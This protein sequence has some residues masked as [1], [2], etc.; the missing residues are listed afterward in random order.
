MKMTIVMLVAFLPLV[1]FAQ[2][3]ATLKI[4]KSHNCMSLGRGCLNSTNNYLTFDINNL[5][6]DIILI[7]VSLNSISD[8][9][10]SFLI[11]NKSD[12]IRSETFFFQ[13]NDYFFN[14]EEREVLNLDKSSFIMRG[15]YPVLIKD[16]KVYLELKITNNNV[17]YND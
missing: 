7:S 4:G 10:K 1:N 9:D 16:D 6:K 3:N 14:E 17:Y 11:G 15:N 8:E 2:N 12:D 13:E 5:N